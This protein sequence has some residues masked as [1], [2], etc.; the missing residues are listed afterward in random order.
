[1]IGA[2]LDALAPLGVRDLTMPT[3]PFKVWQAIRAAKT[4]WRG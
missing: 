1:V 2:I 3:T 4:D